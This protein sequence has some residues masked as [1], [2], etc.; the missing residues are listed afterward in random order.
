VRQRV[1]H[2][3]GDGHSGRPFNLAAGGQRE[4]DG[5]RVFAEAESRREQ[6]GDYRVGGIE[7]RL[8]RE[9]EQ[10]DAVADVLAVQLTLRLYR[11]ARRAGDDPAQV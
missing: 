6:R 4:R 9:G 5:D 2:A 11:P 3:P 7:T 8:Q 10:S 1:H